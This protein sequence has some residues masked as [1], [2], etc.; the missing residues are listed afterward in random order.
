[1][2]HPFQ[3]DRIF[4]RSGAIALL[5]GTGGSAIAQP[6]AINLT[7]RLLDAEN[8]PLPGTRA[9]QV[10]FFDSAK[11]GGTLG[12][13]ET[14]T[15]D[16]SATGAFAVCVEIDASLANTSPLYYE[17]GIDSAESPD[18]AVD[19]ADIFPDRVEIKSVM[20]A[21]TVVQQGPGSGLD[22]DT[23]DGMQAA[24]FIKETDLATIIITID[25][26]GSGVDADQFDGMDSDA[27]VKK[28]ELLTELLGQDGSGSEL[29]AD[30]LDGLDSTDFV[31]EVEY[32]NR[33]G[34]HIPIPSE[35]RMLPSTLS[36][37]GGIM[38]KL[39]WNF[40][41]SQVFSP[42][43]N[44]GAGTAAAIS[45][46][47]VYQVP[48]RIEEFLNPLILKGDPP[49]TRGEI[50]RL[51]AEP[52]L[53]A[54]NEID[55]EVVLN[56]GFQYYYVT[57]V[58]ADGR[59]SEPGFPFVLNTAPWVVYSGDFDIDD[60]FELY[61]QLPVA[62]AQRID[63][64]GNP[65]PVDVEEFAISPTN[66]RFAFDSS[67]LG[68]RF[69]FV[70]EVIAAPPL[71]KGAPDTASIVSPE[72]VPV[73]LPAL[74]FRSDYR[75]SPDGRYLVYV[76]T[77]DLAKGF[78]AP[79][80]TL[81]SVDLSGLT[82]F[83]VNAPQK[84]G[85]SDGAV[86]LSAPFMFESIDRFE[87]TPDARYAI[88]LGRNPPLN[89][90]TGNTSLF[91]VPLSGEEPPLEILF[92][93]FVN[94]TIVDFA[95]SPDGTQILTGTF[96]ILN[97]QIPNGSLHISH[98][99]ASLT[100]TL[101][102]PFQEAFWG[103]TG[104]RVYQI[105]RTEVVPPKSI[106][107]PAIPDTIRYHTYSGVSQTIS[108]PD[109]FFANA[110]FTDDGDTILFEASENP[111]VM[112]EKGVSQQFDL[113]AAPANGLGQSREVYSQGGGEVKAPPVAPPLEYYPSP[114]NFVVAIIA[115]DNIDGVNELLIAFSGSFFSSG[116]V[117]I[118]FINIPKG[119]VGDGG[120]K[121][122]V[123]FT[124]DGSL[125]VFQSGNPGDF[126]FDLYAY[127]VGGDSPAQPIIPSPSTTQGILEFA[128]PYMGYDSHGESEPVVP[129]Q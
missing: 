56:S 1:M 117:D 81:S 76:S 125:A 5:I 9:W 35:V 104:N 64:S 57:A 29:D 108:T 11:G 7:G 21:Q 33:F 79:S 15:V 51:L 115:D 13:P 86:E 99:A 41:P 109:F 63:L 80:Q 95:L 77:P 89:K 92:N 4:V 97:K 70:S 101:D 129:L 60:E 36:A 34:G 126:V 83:I 39:T 111:I 45:G 71:T 68:P 127:E 17:I 16:V 124:P 66:H 119:N 59:E 120:V 94:S 3:L 106:K 93:E 26:T 47:R 82:N 44:G 49:L 10:T 32:E 53:T 123:L 113:F 25:G 62:N 38:R 112:N 118:D 50:L 37:D 14:G 6:G 78:P 46:F 107:G 96:P 18:G 102:V 24:D 55:V 72:P 90:G 103:P 116:V 23:L 43:K 54:T 128:I 8:Q 105:V 27:F 73:S 98:I 48:S 30:L 69:L 75:F 20:F 122:P 31:T 85:P 65:G 114:N 2:K 52:I 91:R 28:V 12:V 87:I 61:A 74:A 19:P 100:R 58:S 22:A 40:G 42:V 88:F 121:G 84:G 67:A 110:K